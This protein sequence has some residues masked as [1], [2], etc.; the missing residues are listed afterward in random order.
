MINVRERGRDTQ[1][2]T[3]KQRHTDRQQ[4]RKDYLSFILRQLYIPL[5]HFYILYFKLITKFSYYHKSGGGHIYGKL[6]IELF[7]IVI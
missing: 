2:Q 7:F 1:R 3:D 5:L 4:G 6:H